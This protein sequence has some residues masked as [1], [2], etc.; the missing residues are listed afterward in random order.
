MSEI[1]IAQ[2]RSLDFHREAVRVR[3][4]DDGGKAPGA[5]TLSFDDFQPLLRRVI[6]RKQ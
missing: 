6:D 4:W 1:E 3:L 5:P 2:F